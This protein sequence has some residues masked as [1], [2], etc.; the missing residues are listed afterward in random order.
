MNDQINAVVA[1]RAFNRFHTSFVGA[2]TPRYLETGM[3]L[4]EA[5]L[6]YEVVRRAPV[7]ASELQTV[8][9]LD[10]GYASRMLRRFE[11]QGW[12]TR[13]RGADA[14]RRPI[15]PTPDGR[16]AFDELDAITRRD[17]ERGLR[18]LGPV[19]QV[20]L[21]EA[22]GAVRSL[23]GDPELERPT[24]RPFRAG[25]MGLITARQAILYA[26]SNGW[27]APMEALLGDVTAT[28]LRDFKPGREQCW[29]AE[30]AGRMAGSI[31][32][33]DSGD[34]RAQLRLLYVEP[35]ARGLGIGATLVS[36]CVDFARAAGYRSIWLWTHT[37]LE[38]ARR[39]YRTAGF[40]ITSTDVHHSFGKPE[41]GETWELVF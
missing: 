13:G 28:F 15:E 24:I 12:V 7:L 2:L 11:D 6:L 1:L 31:F 4:A 18:S 25:D 9:G 40:D 37:V 5:R 21:V 33:V 22:L 32:C 30:R 14:R 26:H 38:N 27:G 23:L 20:T 3:G 36:T 8:L 29:V 17:V 39:L 35:D 16:A 41:Q 34:G 10:A 19:E